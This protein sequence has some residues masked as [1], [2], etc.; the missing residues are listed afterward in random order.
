MKRKLIHEIICGRPVIYGV[1]VRGSVEVPHGETAVIVNSTFTAPPKRVK[2]R[3]CP[4]WLWRAVSR[5]G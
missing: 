3:L 5:E 4:E 2:R 1:R